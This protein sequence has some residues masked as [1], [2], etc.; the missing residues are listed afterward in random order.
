MP[1][2]G[3]LSKADRERGG[4]ARPRPREAGIRRVR[5]DPRKNTGFSGRHKVVNWSTPTT[6]FFVSHVIYS[7]HDDFNENRKMEWLNFQNICIERR[8]G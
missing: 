3:R 5:P 4:G 6:H 1:R 2:R 8:T 7:R